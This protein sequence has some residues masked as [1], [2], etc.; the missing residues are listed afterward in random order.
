MRFFD[1]WKMNIADTN[2]IRTFLTNEDVYVSLIYAKIFKIVNYLIS[3]AMKSHYFL[4]IM[5]S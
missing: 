1:E 4:L 2:Y 3:R 5:I